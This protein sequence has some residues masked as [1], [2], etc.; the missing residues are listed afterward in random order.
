MLPQLFGFVTLEEG[1]AHATWAACAVTVVT[2]AAA[3]VFVAA[4]TVATSAVAV[5]FNN[6]RSGSGS[7]PSWAATTP[8]AVAARKFANLMF[9]IGRAHV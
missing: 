3:V 1:C 9:E 7:A 5:S 4:A 2:S 8:A 6:R